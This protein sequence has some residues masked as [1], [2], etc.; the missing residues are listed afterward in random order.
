MPL[1]LIADFSD[2]HTLWT[3]AIPELTIPVHIYYHAASPSDVRG[4]VFRADFQTVPD[5]KRH[6]GMTPRATK[7]DQTIP[8]GIVG[9]GPAWEARYRAAVLALTRG[10]VAAVFSPQ[11]CDGEVLAQETGG[12]LFHSLRRLISHPGVKALLILESGWSR[13]WAIE[14][15]TAKQMPV[16]VASPVDEAL[17]HVADSLAEQESE[18]AVIVPGALLRSTPATLRLRELVATKLGRI[19]YLDVAVTRTSASVDAQIVEVIDWCRSLLNSTVTE[20]H[21]EERHEGD[22]LVMSCGGRSSSTPPKL[23]EIR[24]IGAG[25]RET[26]PPSLDT[27]FPLV[28]I[29]CQHGEAELL[30][31]IH[32][33]WKT[34]TETGHET[35]ENDR[36]AEQVLLDLFL[37]RVVGGVVPV[38]SWAELAEAC[39]LW[40]SVNG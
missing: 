40:K 31:E 32:L 18:G 7:R 9:G 22:T 3:P 6:Y 37:R 12:Q 17:P 38:P 1:V 15:A 21:R 19:Q 26:A 30:S 25:P 28:H 2:A 39:R 14:L 4:R 33:R 8:L 10:R 29:Q 36:P 11:P 16:F 34:P 5:R 24:L 27:A 13:D 20:I 23:I 35:L